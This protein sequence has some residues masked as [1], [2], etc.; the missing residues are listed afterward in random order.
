ML[1]PYDFSAI[2]GL[3]LGD[4]RI[5]GNDSI[6]LV[7]I[8]VLLGVMPPR[9]RRKNMP[10]MWLYTHIERYKWYGWHLDKLTVRPSCT[11]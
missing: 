4:E 5:E 1:T 7:E 2:T 9:V 10:L 11:L 8:R 6:S 3:K